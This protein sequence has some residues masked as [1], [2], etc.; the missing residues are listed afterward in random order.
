MLAV[1]SRD[2][3]GGTWRGAVDCLSM[4]CTPVFVPR[5]EGLGGAGAGGLLARGA[6]SIDLSQPLRFQ[7]CLPRQT[8]LFSPR[9]EEGIG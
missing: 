2:G 6:K 9:C 7:L 3:I 4:R 1:A 8:D 5:G